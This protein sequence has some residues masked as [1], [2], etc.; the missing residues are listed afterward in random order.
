MWLSSFPP[1]NTTEDSRRR[2]TP[3]VNRSA[4]PATSKAKCCF[5]PAHHAR[6]RLLLLKK[7]PA[8]RRNRHVGWI[9]QPT[10]RDARGLWGQALELEATPGPLA[11]VFLKPCNAWLALHHPWQ[12]KAELL[13]NS[14]S[15]PLSA[16]WHISTYSG[17]FEKVT[18]LPNLA[19][20]QRV[21]GPLGQL[22]SLMEISGVLNSAFFFLNTWKKALWCWFTQIGPLTSQE[23]GK[24]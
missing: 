20:W 9:E 14:R 22:L 19:C 6:L 1:R 16:A 4:E 3:L 2:W 8:G 18:P 10:E 7:I 23:Q 13:S 24:S 21:L 17:S 12:R 15:T 11:E 5:P